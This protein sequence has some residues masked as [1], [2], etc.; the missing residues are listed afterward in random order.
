MKKI[1]LLSL[2]AG[3]L[4]SACQNKQTSATTSP[5][6]ADRTFTDWKENVFMDSMWHTSPEYASVQGYHKYDSLMNVPD[7][8]Y[9]KKL[10]AFADYVEAKLKSFGYDSLSDLNKTDYK[11]I[12][13]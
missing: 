7:S 11:L 8:A 10:L 4:F 9:A 12:E 2:A 1:L 5:S 6:G 13:N 3:L